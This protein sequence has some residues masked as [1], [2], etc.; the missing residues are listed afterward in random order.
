MGK[1]ERD[2]VSIAAE[3]AAAS[4]LGRRNIYAQP[5]FGHLKRTDLLI[6]DKAGNLLRIEAKGKQGSQWP[7]CK[8]ISDRNSVMILVDFTDKTNT[9]RPDFYI[10]TLDDWLAFVKDVIQRFPDK[11]IKMDSDHCPVWTKQVKGGKP[12]RGCGVMVKD[13]IQHKEKWEKIGKL[14]K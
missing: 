12:Y 10:L 11:G 13:V 2:M 3:F 8:G 5:T 6:L 9:E 7:N 14:L 1:I 4:E